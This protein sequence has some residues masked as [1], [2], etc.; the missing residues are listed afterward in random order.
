M[1]PDDLVLNRHTFRPL[2]VTSP[3]PTTTSIRHP[4]DP[5]CTAAVTAL[6]AKVKALHTAN[7]NRGTLAGGRPGK[8]IQFLSDLR[9]VMS[10]TFTR[11]SIQEGFMQ[12]GQ[13]RRDGRCEPSLTAAL[14]QV[15][16]GN[17]A[18]GPHEFVEVLRAVDD[19][20]VPYAYKHGEL[21]EDLLD[22][23]GVIPLDLDHVATK[24][25]ENERVLWQRR[26][27]FMSH[28][29][30]KAQRI[31]ELA[32]KAQVVLDAA[33]KK[34]E[35]EAAKVAKA[36]AAAA[37]KIAKEVKRVETALV[38]STARQAQKDAKQAARDLEKARKILEEARVARAAP[39]RKRTGATA[40]DE[41]MLSFILN[42]VRVASLAKTRT[43]GVDERDTMS[44]AWVCSECNVGWNAWSDMANGE[45]FSGVWP[46]LPGKAK[47]WK[48]SDE[49]DATTWCSCPC[50]LL[51]EKK[52][53]KRARSR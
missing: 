34:K 22:S 16:A 4:R 37:A 13:M 8:I 2:T 48:H 30:I 32:A 26:A 18:L 27:T 10:K 17:N 9:H 51:Q 21:T 41:A 12:T 49:D 11:S 38:A 1:S 31:A 3:L 25:K 19:E 24:K 52:A 15:E 53:A 20:L 14:R 47:K 33:A 6:N 28:D 45:A 29:N 23:T 7:G 40:A 5:G 46:T 50:C 43:S 42:Q 39:K 36:A 44:D 35:K